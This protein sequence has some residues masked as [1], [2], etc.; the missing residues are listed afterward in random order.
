MKFSDA[1]KKYENHFKCNPYYDFE[2]YPKTLEDYLVMIAKRNG[3]I[4]V[5]GNQTNKRS[6]DLELR[7]VSDNK[8]LLNL[9]AELDYTGMFTSNG[10]IEKYSEVGPGSGKFN[11]LLLNNTNVWIK[12]NKELRYCLVLRVDAIKKYGKLRKEVM[13]DHK[14]LAIPREFNRV[15]IRKMVDSGNMLIGEIQDYLF[16]VKELFTLKRNR[17]ILPTLEEY[18]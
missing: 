3:L 11:R 1:T 18:L 9:D 5:R 6:V 12:A 7:R 2:G 17:F 14:G 4:V 15:N 16:M 8:L 10:T 13:S